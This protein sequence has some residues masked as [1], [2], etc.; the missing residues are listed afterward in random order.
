MSPVHWAAVTPMQEADAIWLLQGM[1]NTSSLDRRQGSDAYLLQSHNDDIFR[2]H[3]LQHRPSDRTQRGELNT[4][5]SVCPPACTC[6]WERHKLISK[7]LAMHDCGDAQSRT[8]RLA[9]AMPPH[10]RLHWALLAA[11]R[12]QKVVV[13]WMCRPLL[14]RPVQGS[15]CM[16]CCACVLLILASD[17][18]CSSHA[19]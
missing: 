2:E 11:C 10:E 17:L 8:L 1:T 9:P 5:D 18:V 15:T 6:L 4:I 13:H 7:V 3:T 16:P 19:G 12:P 14:L